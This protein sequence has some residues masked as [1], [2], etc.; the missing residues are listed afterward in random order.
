MQPETTFHIKTLDE[1]TPEEKKRFES[2]FMKLPKRSATFNKFGLRYD[3]NTLNGLGK[4]IIFFPIEVM[5][6]FVDGV[7][8]TRSS[9]GE[10]MPDLTFKGLRDMYH[11]LNA[12]SI[13]NLAYVALHSNYIKQKAHNFLLLEEIYKIETAKRN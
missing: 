8:F 10:A 5:A 4:R 7:T 12:T 9:A 2:I 3:I 13:G 1:F 11:L 6:D